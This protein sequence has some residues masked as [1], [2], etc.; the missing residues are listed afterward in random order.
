MA[1]LP[2]KVGDSVLYSPHLVHATA[3]TASGVPCFDWRYLNPGRSGPKR[4]ESHKAGELVD[5]ATCGKFRKGNNQILTGQGNVD[6][7]HMARWYWPAWIV[8]IAPDGSVSLDAVHPYSYREP[9]DRLKI[10]RDNC[11]LLHRMPDWES[12]HPDAFEA[13]P[14]HPGLFRKG[15]GA[16]KHADAPGLR[17]D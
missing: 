14:E 5:F 17:Y 13:A 1:D 10:T 16:L 15:P 12:S 6:E 4:K 2:Y 7:P 9:E 3:F 8:A 11:F